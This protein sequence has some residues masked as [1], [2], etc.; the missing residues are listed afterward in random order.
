MSDQEHPLSVSKAASQEAG[1]PVIEIT[2]EM[3]DAGVVCVRTQ[4]EGFTPV[5][6]DLALEGL[7]SQLLVVNVAKSHVSA[8][9]YSENL[10][11][12]K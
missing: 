11:G 1:V 3:I 7:V 5:L 4:L 10:L 6:P 2:E 12:L 8:R 9:W